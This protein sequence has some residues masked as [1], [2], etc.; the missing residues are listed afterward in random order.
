M[1]VASKLRQ[2]RGAENGD[3]VCALAAAL[4]SPR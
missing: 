1:L 2:I 4:H 3:E